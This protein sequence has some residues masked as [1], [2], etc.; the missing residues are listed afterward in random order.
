MSGI[1]Q[2]RFVSP[3]RCASVVAFVANNATDHHLLFSGW[4]FLDF[5]KSRT[6]WREDICD[7]INM[8][9]YR[10]IYGMH[11]S[12]K[13]ICDDTLESMSSKNV[14]TMV[15]SMSIIIYSRS[16]PRLCSCLAQLV[17]YPRMMT[18]KLCCLPPDP[19]KG[20]RVIVQESIPILVDVF[21]D[22]Q[23]ASWDLSHNHPLQHDDTY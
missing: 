7:V 4:R 20:H 3:W 8:Y 22:P 21:V 11:P 14:R 10:S 13:Y 17:S 9:K 6:R 5:L 16:P 18:M 1:E 15:K 23:L 2:K 19:L 12:S